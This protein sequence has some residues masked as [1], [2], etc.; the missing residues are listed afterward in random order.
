MNPKINRTR[1]VRDFY[2][3]IEDFLQKKYPLGSGVSLGGSALPLIRRGDFALFSEGA[4]LAVIAPGL[5]A[6]VCGDD[7]EPRQGFEEVTN[8]GRRLSSQFR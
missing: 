1:S 5:S 8:H 7:S 4:G 3:K 2:Q 6:D